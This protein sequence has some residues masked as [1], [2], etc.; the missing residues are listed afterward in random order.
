MEY[1][2]ANMN[3]KL[4]L[5]LIAVAL[6][7][8]VHQNTMAGNIV[9]STNEETFEVLYIKAQ[10]GNVEAQQKFANE[11]DKSTKKAEQGDVEAQ[12]KLGY[13]YSFFISLGNSK[14]DYV[15]GAEWY[16]K[17]AEQGHIQAQYHL[18]LFYMGGMGVDKDIAK[19]IE[20]LTRS[21]SQGDGNAQYTL[22]ILYL[23]G[24]NND[25]PEDVSAILQAT[26]EMVERDNKQAQYALTLPYLLSQT[27]TKIDSDIVTHLLR[28]ITS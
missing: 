10:H 19:G 27:D 3:M 6:T 25:V 24:T 16:T 13:F 7:A 20:W 8:V 2:D 5:T 18:R 26:S 15:K 23:I 12:F 4:I 17:A 1:K 28:A 21:A 22:G 11:M 9:F 14:G